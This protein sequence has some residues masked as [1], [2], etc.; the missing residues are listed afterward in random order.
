MYEL[1]SFTSRHPLRE[2]TISNDESSGRDL[3]TRVS[4]IFLLCR[5]EISGLLE[6]MEDVWQFGR[7]PSQYIK[8]LPNDIS[9]F[10]IKRVII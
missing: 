4:R 6:K 8:I 3:R 1:T 9:Y 5:K 10:K 2:R 7:V